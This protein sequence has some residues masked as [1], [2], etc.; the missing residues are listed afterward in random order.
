MQT[1]P[2]SRLFGLD[3][4]RALA[5]LQVV[6]GHSQFW[7]AET[8][9]HGFPFFH[10]TDGVDMFFVLSGFLIGGILLKD[11]EHDPN[12]SPKSLLH[13]WKRRWFRTLPNYYLILIINYLLV[14]TGLTFGDLAHFDWKFLCFLQ[15]FAAP[16]EGFFWESWSLAVEEWFYLLFPLILVA[17][18][19]WLSPKSAYI[20][21]VA[22]MLI[23]P[24]AYRFLNFDSNMSDQQFDF[25]LRKLVLTRLDA[26]GYGLL[27]A[28]F[29]QNFKAK[30]EQWRWPCFL[31]GAMGMTALLNLHPSLSSIYAQ[32]FFFPLVSI[33]IM[34]WLPLA[35]SLKRFP[36]LVGKAIVYISK[37]SYS[38]Y[39]LNLGVVMALMQAHFTP[40]DTLDQYG[41]FCLYWALVIGLST[42]LY[43]YFEKPM[44]NLR[45]RF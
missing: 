9:L 2:N 19:R 30:W 5:V 12:F 4:F 40:S 32:V 25:A 14:K 28:Y 42:L 1:V 8:P 45:D 10:L 43:R 34:L 38:M 35:T 39:L 21:T 22:M 29:Y 18:I 7:L 37:I 27:A 33:A 13:F 20:F 36:G 41:K 23:F 11:L 6:W 31:F 16:F 24:V 17:G 26:I 15:N 3:L 44:M